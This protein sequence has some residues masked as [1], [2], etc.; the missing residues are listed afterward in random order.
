MVFS[1]SIWL[2]EVYTCVFQ[3]NVN[4]EEALSK[5]RF[6]EETDRATA[7]FGEVS[8]NFCG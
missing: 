5:K 3:V 7:A 1:L 2:P 6:M 8:G 4:M